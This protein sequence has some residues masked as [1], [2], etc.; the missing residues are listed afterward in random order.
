MVS[1]VSSLIQLILFAFSCRQNL[2]ANR[3]Q[4]KLYEPFHMS[5]L[6][7]N[8]HMVLLPVSSSTSS[9]P[10]FT[11]LNTQTSVLLQCSS[12]NWSL[13]KIDWDGG[14]KGLFFPRNSGTFEPVVWCGWPL[15]IKCRI[16]VRL[17]Y[18]LG[19]DFGDGKC[20]AG[21]A[22]KKPAH[23]SPD[24][25]PWKWYKISLFWCSL[26]YGDTIWHVL[27]SWE[28]GDSLVAQ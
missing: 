8:A 14:Q 2:S 20:A 26:G 12:W 7:M 4:T 25:F 10:C 15:L 5:H 11:K 13:S 19:S 9:F 24:I 3:K 23:G 1:A 21:D 16:L 17:P 27:K 18:R 28:T 6:C 22:R